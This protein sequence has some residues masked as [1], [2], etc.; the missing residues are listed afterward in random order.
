MSYEVPGA[1]AL[2]NVPCRYGDS[3]L[4]VRGPQRPLDAPYVAFL[5]SSDTYGKFVDRPFPALAEIALGLPCVNLGC[6]NAGVDAFAQ[7][8]EIMRIAAAA[9]G[10]VVQVSGAQNLSNRFYRV[11]PR[12]NDRF[13]EATPLLDAIYPEVDFTDFHFNKHMLYTLYTLSPRRFDALRQELQAVWVARMRLVLR[14]CGSRA[15]V[16]WLRYCDETGPLGADPLMVTR[17]MLEQLKPDVGKILE[18]PVTA[19]GRCGDMP[20]MRFGAMQAPAAELAI[21]PTAH[22]QIAERVVEAL[23]QVH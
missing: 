11:H 6:L 2:E 8:A 14:Q 18:I 21:G 12:R 22:A 16:L 7:D 9:K 17:D 3:R 23:P 5:G 20:Q 1:G 4:M 13:L 10:V 19:A 15:V